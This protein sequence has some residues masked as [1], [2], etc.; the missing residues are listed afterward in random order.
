[1]FYGGTLMWPSVNEIW[2]SQLNAIIEI[3]ELFCALASDRDMQKLKPP[4]CEMN[5]GQI[6]SVLIPAFYQILH[7]QWRPCQ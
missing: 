7:A 5:T 2:N 4:L 6:S 3:H 1:V